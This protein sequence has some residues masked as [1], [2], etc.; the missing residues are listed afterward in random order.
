MSQEQKVE[1][2]GVPELFESDAKLSELQTLVNQRFVNFE[3]I[4]AW[5][6]KANLVEHAETRDP[7]IE[8]V[9]EF[10]AIQVYDTYS[11][12]TYRIQLSGEL[13]SSVARLTYSVLHGA[14]KF[15]HGVISGSISRRFRG[16]LFQQLSD[17]LTDLTREPSLKQVPLVI[18]RLAEFRFN[19]EMEAELAIAQT[20]EKAVDDY[21]TRAYSRVQMQDSEKKEVPNERN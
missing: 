11:N 7:E 2:P 14:P 17:Y 19:N 4:Y 10:E 6:K 5:A 13:K 3:R 9:D 18:K 8:T 16:K 20:V 1:L 21:V 12:L 15:F